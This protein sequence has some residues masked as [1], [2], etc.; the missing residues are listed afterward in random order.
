MFVSGAEEKEHNDKNFSVY[1]FRGPGDNIPYANRDS[2]A[3]AHGAHFIGI[4]CIYIPILLFCIQL[5]RSTEM[6]TIPRR[7]SN[8]CERRNMFY[9]KL[10]DLFMC[11][12]FFF[13]FFFSIFMCL[14]YLLRWHFDCCLLQMNLLIVSFSRLSHDNCSLYNK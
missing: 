1:D 7:H 2:L 3:I 12:Y 11:C 5:I 13:F 6:P 4:T 9:L 14:V 8:D 10:L